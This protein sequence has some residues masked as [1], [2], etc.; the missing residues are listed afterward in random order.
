M[1]VFS[2]Q[3]A[4][5]I[6]KI[7]KIS[8]I[9]LGGIAMQTVIQS[10]G[11]SKKYHSQKALDNV[12]VNVNQGDIYGLIGRNGAGKTTF[13][14]IINRQIKASSGTYTILGQD[15]THKDKS[16]FRIGT[17]IEAPGLYSNMNAKQNLALKCQ[18]YG[19]HRKGYIQELLEIVGL[20]D[21][22]GKKVKKF[23]LGMKQ[24]LGLAMALVGDP[25]ILLLDEPTNG[26][27]PQGIA[28]F[29]QIIHRLNKDRNITIVISS[30][31][32]GELSK[33]INK[34]GII[35]QGQL[36]KEATLEELDQENQDHYIL[37]AHNM[38]GVL[39]FLNQQ[40]SLTNYQQ[41]SPSEIQIF[42]FLDQPELIPHSLIQAGILFEEFSLQRFSLED[43][44]IQ[45]TG[46]GQDA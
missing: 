14:K 6:S 5:I 22:K 38:D 8:R 25:D 35:D 16:D 31:I 2:L 44:F 9:S 7:V 29:R 24:R 45:L 42:D 34:I 4:I 36:I 27:D 43:Y 11:L 20:L 30:H 39:A 15:A 21:T 40:L 41:T 3:I 32:L 33:F 19:I 17:L 13:M 10:Q 28:E 46:G 12:N 18:L 1:M 26:M 23:S 37:K